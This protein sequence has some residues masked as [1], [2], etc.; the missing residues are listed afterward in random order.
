MSTELRPQGRAPSILLVDDEP[1]LLLTL[2]LVLKGHG[3]NVHTADSARAARERLNRMDVDV[4]V[5]VADQ[6]MP[7][8][9]GVSLLT[10]LREVRPD[11]I[12][13]L[14]TGYVDLT[15]LQG[16]INDA[17]IWHLAR[18]P[19]ANTELVSLLERAVE[20]HRKTRRLAAS[21]RRFR[22]LLETAPV[23]VLSVTLTGE[24]TRCNDALRQIVPYDEPSVTNLLRPGEWS[25]LLR[26]LQT[27]R[28]VLQRPLD[29]AGVP[30]LANASLVHAEHGGW[31][32]QLVLVDER[33]SLDVDRTSSQSQGLA[34]V[35]QITDNVVH[36]FKNHLTVVHALAE[37]LQE[38]M[39]DGDG[40]DGSKDIVW[41]TRSASELAQQLIELTQTTGAHAQRTD[42]NQV[43]DVLARMLHSVSAALA[44]ALARTLAFDKMARLNEQLE[45]QI[46]THTHEL[47]QTRVRLYQLE[48]VASLSVLSAGISHELN[49]PLSVIISTAEELCNRLAEG[50]DDAEI[51]NLCL[52]AARRGA[53]IVDDMSRFTRSESQEPQDVDIHQGLDSTLRLLRAKLSSRNIQVLQQRTP[54][55]LI[56]R[57]T[58]GPLYQTFVNLILNAAQAVDEGGTITI[59]TRRM[60]SDAQIVIS[61]NGPGIPPEVHDRI[62]EPFFTTKAADRGT[63]LGLAL[64]F[65]FIDEQDGTIREVGS[66]GS[67]AR[68]EIVLPMEPTNVH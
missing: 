60:G 53:G 62:F 56:V 26:D 63:G 13:I 40:Q 57:G 66:P 5:V 45:E 6:R 19:W 44:L 50:S 46:E 24:I 20:S 43:V 27:D 29:V 8:E 7:G 52:T 32:V 21:R 54:D 41:S 1:A 4:D 11:V 42:I 3:F 49:T 9:T 18:K 68:F 64:C 37:S 65:T 36:D 34:A 31:A 33:R 35:R 48:K 38:A 23:A 47:A 22:T 39:P 10:W 15:A 25:N 59:E 16:A 17:G 30:M 55:P 51:A 67:G 2:R 28:L 12:R 58:P 61:D 14:L